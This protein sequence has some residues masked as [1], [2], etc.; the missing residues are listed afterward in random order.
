MKINCV[1]KDDMPGAA[2]PISMA[3]LNNMSIMD[4]LAVAP[5]CNRPVW[6]LR[7]RQAAEVCGWVS[8]TIL[9]TWLGLVVLFAV[10]AMVVAIVMEGVD[11]MGTNPI[12]YTAAAALVIYALLYAALPRIYAW[13]ESRRYQIYEQRA[14]AMKAHGT[15]RAGAHAIFHREM[16]AE[17]QAQATINAARIAA[18]PR[19][20]EITIHRGRGHHGH[21]RKKHKHKH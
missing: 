14:A 9:A 10:S 18:Q 2:P 20:S 11:T 16:L 17:M 12:T 5:D 21:G 19:R 3:K 7:S 6:E 13:S 15:S 8:G 1:T 4:R